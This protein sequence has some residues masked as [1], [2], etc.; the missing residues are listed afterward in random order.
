M[1]QRFLLNG[2]DTKSAA[3]AISREHHPVAQALAHE[4]ESALPVIQLA[5][6]RTQPALDAPVQ[7]HRPPAAG[8][9]RLPQFRDNCSTISFRN[10][11]L[12]TVAVLPPKWHRGLAK[13]I[14]E[15]K[16]NRLSASN[17]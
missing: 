13:A 6:P 16:T 15:P 1:V 8:I 14:Q 5:K 3:A 4:A 17:L 9:I 7:Q 11:S 12:H 10:Q 2:I